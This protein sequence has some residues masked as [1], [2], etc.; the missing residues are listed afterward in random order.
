MYEQ[1]PYLTV[2]AVLIA[3]SL[4]LPLPEDIPLLTGGYLCHLGKAK[5]AI[6]IA[7]GLTGVLTGDIMLFTLGRRLGHHVVEHRLFRRLVNPSRLL[8]AERMFA[9][10][11]VKIIFVGR[12][13]PGL[14]PMIFMAAGVLKVRPLV[15]IAVNGAAACI[16]VPTLVI[17]GNVFGGSLDHVKHEVR[18]VSHTLALV[19]IV[20]AVIIGGIWLHRRQKRLIASEP[21]PDVTPEDLAHMEPGSPCEQ[22]EA[23][24]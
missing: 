9:H 7:V 2:F 11:G 8:A 22:P 20:A 15:F 16:S 21:V 24:T 10:H 23:K 1:L 19:A 3:A 12:F 5:L 4:G 14:R 6:M 17:L 13:L 18:V